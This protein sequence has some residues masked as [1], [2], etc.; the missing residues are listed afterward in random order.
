LARLQ[1]LADIGST[2]TKLCLVD[3]DGPEVLGTAMAPTTI[4]TDVNGGLDAALEKLGAPARAAA[5]TL[6]AS[7]AA[8]GLCIAAVGLVPELTMKAARLAALG[9]GGKVVAAFS[10]K[11]TA[12]DEARLREIAPDL[13][14]LAGG[15]DGGDV[16]HILHNA[17]RLVECLPDVP[18]VVAGNRGARDEL[19]RLF[20]GRAGVR[21]AAN[22]MP[23]VRRLDLAPAREC[24]RA[25]FLERIVVAKG[26]DRLRSRA[27]LVM[28]TPEAVLR[29]VTLLSRGHGGEPG[30]GDLLAVDIGGATTD[31]YSCADGRPESP[32]VYLRGLIEPFEK[33]TVEADVGMRHTLPFLME[34]LDLA[35]VASR[36]GCTAEDLRAWADAI[37]TDP[38]RLPSAG[39]QE[40]ID[41]ALAAAGLA[42]AVERHC[43]RV[44][45]TYTPEGRAYIQE[46]KDLS[47]V[48]WVVGSGGPLAAARDPGAI[49][50]GVRREPGSPSLRPAAPEF[51]VDRKYLL[52]AMGLLAGEEP[53]AALAL[54][55][56]HLEPCAGTAG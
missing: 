36:A 23:E 24:I 19:E 51:L 11:L 26:L 44:E 47:R 52:W 43:G 25:A 3:P 32:R 8:G 17:R 48:R 46:G 16:V 7:S 30:L 39:L 35:G 31:V 15:T 55:K 10:F 9:A 37:R 4:A 42:L 1:L 38:G 40:R 18:L 21:F 50:A 2:F 28:P 33:R 5:R 22:V 45:E 34:Q 53:A 13:V 56:K 27:E 54:M 14:L 41:A 6:A 12:A 49:L 20:A 29:A